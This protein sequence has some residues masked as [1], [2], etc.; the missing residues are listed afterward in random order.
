MDPIL[1]DR[2]RILIGYIKM[3]TLKEQLNRYTYITF[4]LVYNNIK[5]D[6]YYDIIVDI[7]MLPPY[8]LSFDS[9]AIYYTSA[10]LYVDSD[11]MIDVEIFKISHATLTRIGC[12]SLSLF[13]QL[14][15]SKFIA[16]FH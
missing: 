7:L 6:T 12:F 3:D 14:K 13:H 4:Y 1:A 2:M 16:S 5:C 11:D 10:V 8:P 15:I 9:I